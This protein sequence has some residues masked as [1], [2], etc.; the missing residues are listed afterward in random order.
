MNGWKTDAYL[1]AVTYD[2][3]ADRTKVAS[4]KDLFVAHG[5]YVRRNDQTLIHS[6]SKYTAFVE[7]FNAQP[8]VIYNGQAV[9]NFSLWSKGKRTAL[10]INNEVLDGHFDLESHLIKVRIRATSESPK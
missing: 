9:N 8:K 1:M 5:S 6:L 2:A 3:A 4:V 10:D 7:G